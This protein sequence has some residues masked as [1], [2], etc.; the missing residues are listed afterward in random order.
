VVAVPDDLAAT[1]DRLMAKK[2]AGAVSMANKAGLLVAGFAK[3][4][5]LIGQ[6][7]AA[8]VIHAA[9]G[10][11]GGAEK[12]DR[13]YKALVGPEEFEKTVV[14]ELTGPELD[15]AI[16]RSNVVHAAASEG[17][18]SRSMLQEALRLR[19]YRSG[20]PLKTTNSSTG[21]A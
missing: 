2:L 20:A 10:A 7:R 9:D 19:R 14:N 11:P 6:G 3:V 5:A 18:A 15:L 16:G 1:I 12:L 21:R 17:G 4:D 13:K 8:V